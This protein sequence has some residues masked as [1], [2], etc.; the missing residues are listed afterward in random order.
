MVGL[1]QAARAGVSSE[2][3]DY[4]I[5]GALARGS[6]RGWRANEPGIQTIRLLFDHPQTIRVIRLVYQKVD[7]LG[8]I[9]GTKSPRISWWQVSSNIHS[10][11]A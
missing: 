11:H 3:K 1:E 6:K 8:S 2:A 10:I 9:P 4:P 5:E 7:L